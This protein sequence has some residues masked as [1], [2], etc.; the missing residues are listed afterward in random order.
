MAKRS[1][2]RATILYMALDETAAA[3]ELGDCWSTL[4]EAFP[5]AVICFLLRGS[6]VNG[7]PAANGHGTRKLT[8]EPP[9][10]STVVRAPGRYTQ[11]QP[12]GD[13][14]SYVDDVMLRLE[15]PTRELGRIMQ[16]AAV[17]LVQ[18]AQH[19]NLPVSDKTVLMS[20]SAKQAVVVQQ[21]L[22]QCGLEVQRVRSVPANCKEPDFENGIRKQHEGTIEDA[23]LH[24][25]VV[26]EFDALD[27]VSAQMISVAAVADLRTCT[28]AQL[29]QSLMR[30]MKRALRRCVVLP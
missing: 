21:G 1:A 9:G 20:T 12:F 29:L 19:F 30:L 17:E 3:F 22:R 26:E 6:Y 28:K 2:L 4:C 15:P 27:E 16:T 7:H 13:G 24:G 11:C 5:C 25:S 14:V 8:G 18:G 10:K 23:M